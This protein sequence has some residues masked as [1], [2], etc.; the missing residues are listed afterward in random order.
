MMLLEAAQQTLIGQST[1]LKETNWENLADTSL[2][3]SDAR[4]FSDQ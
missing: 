3:K 2:L 4:V 1:V